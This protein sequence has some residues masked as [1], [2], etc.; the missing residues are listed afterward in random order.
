MLLKLLKSNKID[1]F[2]IPNFSNFIYNEARESKTFKFFKFSELLNHIKENNFDEIYIYCFE[3]EL[4]N[5][6]E[7]RY[8]LRFYGTESKLEKK[9]I[10][11][12]AKY[13]N[14]VN[15]GN[16]IT[17]GEFKESLRN[18]DEQISSSELNAL[19]EFI[20]YFDKKRLECIMNL[21]RS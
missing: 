11:T 21:V 7:T 19:T 12:L 10:E 20:K 16:D 13:F 18:L 9:T 1:Y 5:D 4:T 15:I 14:A 17:T 3:S 6:L 2:T 8:A